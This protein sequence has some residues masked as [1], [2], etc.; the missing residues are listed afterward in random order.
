MRWLVLLGLGL[1]AF[2]A[3][4]KYKEDDPLRAA[5]EAYRAG[6]YARA[7][8]LYAQAAKVGSDPGHAT[9][10]CAA[11]L[12]CQGKFDEASQDYQATRATGNDTRTA[13]AHYDLGNCALR[14]ACATK[15]R[16]DAAL[17]HRAVAHYQACLDH[18]AKAD[19]EEPTLVAHARYNQALARKLLQPNEP[20]PEPVVAN[21]PSPKSS[22]DQSAMAK[23]GQQLDAAG[24]PESSQQENQGGADQGTK[25]QPTLTAKANKPEPKPQ[26]E[27][28]DH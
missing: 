25:G 17:V 15:D 14:Q 26:Q 16:P 7:A 24:Q 13:R 11:A 20:Q 21:P 6:D 5:E 28:C 19:L 10:N 22:G 1:L 12:Y 4:W 9:F 8:A 3:A 23:D 27:E 2:G 18:T